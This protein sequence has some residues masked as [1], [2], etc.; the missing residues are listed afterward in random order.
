MRAGPAVALIAALL[1]ATTCAAET[2]QFAGSVTVRSRLEGVG[3]LSG[4][5]LSD[6]GGS[7]VALSDR[8][9]LF[10]GALTRKGGRLT[11]VSVTDGVILTGPDG[12]ALSGP[13]TDAEG[14]ARDR[15][16]R[17]FVSF[18]GRHRV[19]RYDA[20][21]LHPQPLPQPPFADAL[22][23]NSGMEALAIDP[24]GRLYT[25]PERSGAL[26]RPFPVWRYNGRWRQVF[27]I[28]RR[29]PFLPVGADFGPDGRLYLLERDFTGIGF[30]SR[31]R[32]FTLDAGRATGET[33]LLVSRNRQ[34][35]NLEGIAAWRDTDGAIRLTMVS[36]D[37]FRWFQRT[38]IV[39][40]VLPL[41][42]PGQTH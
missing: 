14:L 33:V 15:H 40:Y 13:M 17:L 27:T 2:A 31:I 18:E 34:F 32:A 28:P 19:W 10:R 21:G 23:T 29:G 12:Q 8:G 26:T 38:E 9:R 20:R 42:N 37:N 3:G 24:R 39:E 22:Q 36:D 6:D 16:G 25:L 35:D 30:R 11:G 41:A 5:D 1:L 4:L 7:F